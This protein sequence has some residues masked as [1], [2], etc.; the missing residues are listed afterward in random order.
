M[1]AQTSYSL[2]DKQGVAVFHHVMQMIT[3][4]GIWSTSRPGV[5]V[6]SL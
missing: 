6:L 5:D 4:C 3:M 1:I 2:A